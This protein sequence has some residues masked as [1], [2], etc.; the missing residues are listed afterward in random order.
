MTTKTLIKRLNK[1]VQGLQEANNEM[2][3]ILDLQRTRIYEAKE[4]WRKAHREPLTSP[5]LGQLVAWLMD[6]AG[7]KY[8]N[9]G[10][11]KADPLLHKAW[12]KKWGKKHGKT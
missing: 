7:L 4:H 5:D 2:E 1:K 9:T 12:R 10:L 6:K 8:K 3:C 11:G